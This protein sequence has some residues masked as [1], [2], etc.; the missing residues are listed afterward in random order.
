MPLLSAL[1]D[2]GSPGHKQLHGKY[3]AQA[4]HQPEAAYQV[5]VWKHPSNYSQL[6]VTVVLVKQAS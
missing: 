4:D 1:E 5:P 2:D 6:P 3:V